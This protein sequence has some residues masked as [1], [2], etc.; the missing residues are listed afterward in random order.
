MH[1]RIAAVSVEVPEGAVDLPDPGVADK[2]DVVGATVEPVQS[3]APLTVSVMKILILNPLS[4]LLVCIL[5][6]L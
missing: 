5:T 2:E 3:K 1:G 6:G 4:T